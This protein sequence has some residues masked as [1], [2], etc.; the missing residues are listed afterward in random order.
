MNILLINPGT[1]LGKPN[2]D[3]NIIFPFGL[4]YIAK[5]A[6]EEGCTVDVWDFNKE[7]LDLVNAINY[8]IKKGY[9]SISLEQYDIIGITGI[10]SQYIYIQF[11]VSEIKEYSNAL[12]ILGGP[13]ATYSYDVVL[14]NTGVDICVIGEG[15]ET[16]REIIQASK[17]RNNLSIIDSIDKVNIKGIAYNHRNAFAL[18]GPRKQ[19]KI[20]DIEPAYHLFDMGYYATHTGMVDVVKPFY[21]NKRSASLITSRGCPYNCN[22]CSKSMHGVRTKTLDFLYSEMEYLINNYNIQFIHFVDELLFLNKKRFIKF[23]NRIEKYH[24]LWDCQAR[25]NLV[26][27]KSLIVAKQSGCVC[28]GFGIESGSQKILDNMNKQIKVEEIEKY[29]R[30]CTKINLPVKIQIIYGYPGESKET[31]Q[32]TIN[33]FKRLGLPARRFSVITPLPGSKLYEE[34]KRNGF[35]GDY[36][37]AE[38][39]EIRYIES[40]SKNNG[41]VSKILHYNRTE[42]GRDNFWRYLRQTENTLLFNFVKFIIKNP[43]YVIQHWF[44]YK[45]YIRNWFDIKGKLRNI[46]KIKTIKKIIEMVRNYGKKM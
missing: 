23:C 20:I 11:V 27:E 35:I 18:R 2:P 37:E 45:M 12:I 41:S 3:D 5:V 25:I 21:K 43:K 16:F 31:L 10:V 24:I 39:S 40:L 8:I 36:E 34:S 17:N 19:L 7:Q 30:F 29:L 22:F 32:E 4:G 13:L 44:V 15:E 14:E 1:T 33:L 28:V 6:E 38:T 26:D 46:I 42:F 9:K